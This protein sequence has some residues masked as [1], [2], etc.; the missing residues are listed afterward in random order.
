[1]LVSLII[2]TRG[3]TD[4]LN[5]LFDS[6]AA[7]TFDDF[8]VIVVDQNKDDALARFL[9]TRTTRFKVTTIHTPDESGLSRGRNTG[10][11]AA[12]GSIVVF[13]DDDCWYPPHFLAH[14]LETME[15]LGADILAGRAANEAGRDINGRFEPVACRIHRGNVWTTGI[16]WVVFFKRTALDGVGGFDP[17]I[18]IGAA[19]PWQS[20]EGQ[21]IMLRALGKGMACFYDPSIYGHHAEF[22]VTHPDAAVCRKGR[23]YGRGLG[24]VLRIHGYSIVDAGYWIARSV[25][26]AGQS[27]ML[28]NVGRFNYYKSVA[29]GRSEGWF[30]YIRN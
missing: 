6:L 28:G 26:R 15:R 17:A 1:M 16:E 23:A 13:P 30:N 29:L 18:G 25:F 4:A 27:L 11:S 10:L 3:R 7:Q 20:C 21:D 14:G 22:V 9:A 12:S 24:H 2:S 8:E 5:P 19:T